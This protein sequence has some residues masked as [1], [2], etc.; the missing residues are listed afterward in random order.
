MTPVWWAERMHTVCGGRVR[1][2]DSVGR[3]H[4]EK[5]SPKP[6]L[7]GG[8]ETVRRQLLGIYVTSRQC[9]SESSG[10]RWVS[11]DLMLTRNRSARDGNCILLQIW[12]QA[13]RVCG[14]SLIRTRTDVLIEDTTVSKHR[15]EHKVQTN[16]PGGAPSHT[17]K[18]NGRVL[19]TT[20]A[21]HVSRPLVAMSILY[22]DSRWNGGVT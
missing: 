14:T 6:D 13:T 21:V 8:N 7:A 4:M 5:Y 1:N 20:S 10:A 22:Y 15:Y 16:F 17:R 3:E 18:D 12:R 9:R 19:P 2:A 11:L